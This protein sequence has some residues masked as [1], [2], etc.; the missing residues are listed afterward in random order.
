MAIKYAT[1]FRATAR[2][3]RLAF[4]FC[5]AWSYSCASAGLSRGAILAA[6][7]STVC[8]RNDVLA[9]NNFFNNTYGLSR[10]PLRYNNFG[11]T[12]GGPFYIPGHYNSSKTKTFFFYSQEWRRAIDY[13]TFVSGQMPTPNELQGIL[14][15]EVCTGT[16]YD[17]VTGACLGPTTTRITN[18]DP[19]AEAYIKDIYAKLP[20]A[21][22][23][24]I[25]WTGRNVYDFNEELIR[26]D[27][28]FNSKLS[29]FVRYLN[30]SI[31][32]QEP[33]GLFAWSNLPDVTDTHTSAP[34]NGLAIH[35]TIAFSPTL[36]NEVGYGYAHGAIDTQPVGLATPVRSPDVRPNLPFPDNVRLPNL[37]FN[38]GQGIFGFGPWLG[39]GQGTLLQGQSMVRVKFAGMRRS[40]R[41][42]G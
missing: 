20:P 39:S 22:N 17:G 41:T 19:T 18:F 16:N 4:P 42:Q 38:V 29:A 37:N 24:T 12:I 31:P 5:L 7:T 15:Q 28:V 21:D 14:P 30:D 11:F 34:G 27:Q 40:S 9:A 32:T 13:S 3:A 26:V 35:T 25:A 10:P 36:W 6:S 1:S 2:V 33:G 23:G 8:V